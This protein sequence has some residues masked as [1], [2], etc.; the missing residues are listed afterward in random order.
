MDKKVLLGLVLACVC[1]VLPLS[2]VA[3]APDPVITHIDEAYSK[4]KALIKKNAKSEGDMTTT[5]HYYVPGQGR[6]TETMKFYCRTVRGNYLMI[7]EDSE[8]HFHYYPLYFVTRDY[9]IGKRKYHEEYLYDSTTERPIFALVQDYDDQGKRIERRF[10]FQDSNVYAMLG[11]EPTSRTD[12]LV[13]YWAEELKHGFD[14]L[15]RN[16]KE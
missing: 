7:D 8:P 2:V 14:D 6:T 9:N 11:P 12:M 10:Y 4:T 16:P 5:I 15:M 13:Y 1:S 3:Q